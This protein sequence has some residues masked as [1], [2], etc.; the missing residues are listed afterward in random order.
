MK[1]LVLGLLAYVVPTFLLGFFWHLVL[2]D[3]YYKALAM[4]RQDII[5]PF[6]FL[7]MLIQGL[8][9]GWMFDQAF[10][11]RPGGFLAVAVSYGILGALLSW[12]FTTLAVSAKNVMRSV[13][14]YLL[15]ETGFT[16]VQWVMVAPLTVLAFRFARRHALSA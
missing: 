13:P 9:F 5:I 12:S 11:D 8:L 4:Y 15:I 16:L 2:F 1:R 14:D 7:S 10:A 3:D 6:G